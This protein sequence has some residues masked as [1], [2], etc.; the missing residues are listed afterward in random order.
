MAASRP[1]DRSKG[2]SCVGAIGRLWRLGLLFR[3]L[4]SATEVWDDTEVALHQTVHAL[5]NAYRQLDLR[6]GWEGEGFRESA[7]RAL[8]TLEEQLP[9][10][11]G[12]RPKVTAVGH[13]H[14]DVAWLWPIWRTRQKVAHTVAT[15]LHLMER[16]P[17]YHFA[18]SAPQTWTYVREDD[19]ELYQRM[20]ARTAEGRLE[21]VGVMWL[22]CDANLPSGEALVRQVKHGLAFYE[23]ETGQQPPAAWLP[24]SF[25]YS[26]ALPTVLAGFGVRAFVTTKLSWNRVNRM[27][28]DTFRWRGVDG[29]E[30]LAHFV[31][32]TSAEVGH[33][34]DPQWHTYNG[35]MT[36]TEIAGLWAHYRGKDVNDELLYL[37]GHGDGGGGPTEQMVATAEL[38]SDLPGLPQVRMGR[39]SDFFA[40]LAARL[41][42]VS[43]PTWSGDLTMEGHRGTYTS[44]ARTKRGNRDLEKAAREAEWAN[45]WAVLDGVADDR[46]NQI[47]GA[48]ITLLRNQFH[49][50]L[51]GSSIAQV[52]VDTA[53]EHAA[54]SRVLG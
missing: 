29:S 11:G 9:Q 19:P 53:A 22:E 2:S 38:L 6:D 20:L 17:D 26:A 5:D 54:A 36:P 16:H 28:A 7:A 41:D 39:S 44:Q 47:D 46:Q 4:L 3:T 23:T 14:L 34:A 33:P 48:W 32:A 27:P 40:R 24:D 52:Y 50:I 31:T 43:L 42:G 37:F 8:A 1:V 35:S 12:P 51:P 21:P 25:G 13:A 45:A 49:D 15:A 10:G 18:L 30:V